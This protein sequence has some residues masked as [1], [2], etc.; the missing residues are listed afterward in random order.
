MGH[1]FE[2][3]FTRLSA[4][5]AGQKEIRALL[6][7]RLTSPQSSTHLPRIGSKKDIQAVTGWP[8]GTIYAKVAQMPSG[9]VIRG[10]SKRLLFDLDKFEQWIKT[11]V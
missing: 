8:D 7:N 2:E 6:I 1:T 11:A 4:I 5:E 9:I 10:R 3:L